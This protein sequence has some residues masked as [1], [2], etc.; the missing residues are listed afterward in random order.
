MLCAVLGVSYGLEPEKTPPPRLV[1]REPLG[2]LGF[3]KAQGAPRQALQPPRAEAFLGPAKPEPAAA[4]IEESVEP[5][6]QG[7]TVT[8]SGILIGG[9]VRYGVINGVPYAE[10]SIV[11]EAGLVEKVQ[12]QGVTIVAENG[13]K[14]FVGIGKRVAL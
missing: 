1:T 11:P 9:R 5:A 3:L 12:K 6:R 13:R 8:V 4:P 7:V 2:D 10:G 14:I